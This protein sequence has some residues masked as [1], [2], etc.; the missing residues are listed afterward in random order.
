MCCSINCIVNILAKPVTSD[1]PS[2]PYETK[3]QTVLR[4][5]ECLVNSFTRIEREIYGGVK[6]EH[7]IHPS[8]IHSNMTKYC[9]SE[10][11][12]IHP[13]IHITNVQELELYDRLHKRV[14]NFSY[15]QAYAD[16]FPDVNK[17]CMRRHKRT[18]VDDETKA[19]NIAH[20]ELVYAPIVNE[21]E[22]IK[23]VN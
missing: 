23:S 8:R 9:C 12:K 19:D 7:W 2:Q 16:G 15:S 3:R 17:S 18:A 5:S 10:L 13:K 4:M 11:E 6:T 20:V 1:D 21:C 14:V 22:F